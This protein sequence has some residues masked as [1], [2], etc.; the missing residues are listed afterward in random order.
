MGECSQG[1]NPTKRELERSLDIIGPNGKTI[2]VNRLLKMLAIP[3]DNSTD[4]EIKRDDLEAAL[5]TIFGTGS[6]IIMH[7]IDRD[8][9]ST[10][11]SASN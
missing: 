8:R 2:L 9:N 4:I 10:R 3:I 6:K 7:L 5:N 11:V 1:Y